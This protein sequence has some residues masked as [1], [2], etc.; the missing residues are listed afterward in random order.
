MESSGSNHLPISSEDLEKRENQKS[1]N[2]NKFD[3]LIAQYRNRC[4][5]LKVLGMDLNWRIETYNTPW[6]YPH[7]SKKLNAT[8]LAKAGFIRGT[9]VIDAEDLTKFNI[10]VENEDDDSVFCPFCFKTLSDFEDS[11]VPFTEHKEHR[12]NCVFINQ[13]KTSRART[14]QWMDV[15]SK[16][17]KAA[18]SE[19]TINTIHQMHRAISNAHTN[20]SN[21]SIRENLLED[22]DNTQE[23]ENNCPEVPLDFKHESSTKHNIKTTN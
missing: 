21:L 15:F 18:N 10:C 19:F 20:I 17:K 2:L 8:T 16:T 12:T 22:F 6:P 13:V 7:K 1:S 5:N 23:L 9:C 11:D 14:T 4:I 3:S